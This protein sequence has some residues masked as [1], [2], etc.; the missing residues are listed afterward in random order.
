MQQD[1]KTEQGMA[2]IRAKSPLFSMKKE[3]PRP[4]T[5]R[6]VAQFPLE[7]RHKKPGRNPVFL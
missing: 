5:E 1:V 7:F 6:S 3:G 4:R 2:Q